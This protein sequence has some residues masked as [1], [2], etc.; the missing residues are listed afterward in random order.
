MSELLIRKDGRAI[1]GAD[2]RSL[3][4]EDLA[5]HF[6]RLTP[7]K[8]IRAKCLDCACYSR[9]EVRKCVAI[10]CPLW[11]FRMRKNP[12]RKRKKKCDE[13]QVRHRSAA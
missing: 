3:S 8:A 2:P 11:P 13:Q 12:W 5:G 6:D 10:R 4:P 7:M 9:T 1:E